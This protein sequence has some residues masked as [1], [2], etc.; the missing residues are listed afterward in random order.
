MSTAFKQNKM[1]FVRMYTQIIGENAKYV[2]KISWV[3]N[4]IGY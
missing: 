4:K 2:L 3:S 1:Q